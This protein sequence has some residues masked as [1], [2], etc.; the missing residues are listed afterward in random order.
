M[1]D[2]PSDYAFGEREAIEDEVFNLN[3]TNIQLEHNNPEFYN[4]NWI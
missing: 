4:S 1:D 3:S 2:L